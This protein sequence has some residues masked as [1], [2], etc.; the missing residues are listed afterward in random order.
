[1]GFNPIRKLNP[2]SKSSVVTGIHW[3]YFSS[4]IT[5]NAYLFVWSLISFSSWEVKNNLKT[6]K[7]LS[8]MVKVGPTG[9]GSMNEWIVGML[10]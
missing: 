8:G 9:D 3:L 4:P 10:S 6:S 7:G 2:M 5:S 1:M